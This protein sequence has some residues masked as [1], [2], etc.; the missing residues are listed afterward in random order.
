VLKLIFENTHNIKVIRTR[1]EEIIKKADISVDVGGEYNVD[2]NR[3][4]HHQVG[5]AGSREN[6]IPYA[7]FGLVWKKYGGRLCCGQEVAD[8]MDRRLVQPTDAGDSG[9]EIVTKKYDGIYPYE[10]FD[11]L[12]TFLPLKG[13][14]T[15]LD[16][17]FDNATSFARRILQREIISFNNKRTA[18]I[19]A[20]QLYKNSVDKRLLVLSES[21]SF[22]NYIKKFS[23]LLFVVFPDSD[24]QWAIKTVRDDPNNF[25]DRKQLPENWAGKR[26]VELEKATGVMDAVFCSNGR[27]IAK[28][29][30][31]E[32][33]LK[34]AEIALNS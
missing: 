16:L 34:L 4:D 1:D 20:E 26:D 19:E 10:I 13:E 8:E 17:A 32:A 15:N 22:G 27:F 21:L 25:I 7:S 29:K 14:T 3:F 24:G 12:D 30:T 6:G 18:F 5:G 2:K 23:D 33:I 9:V 31:K 11:V 28:A